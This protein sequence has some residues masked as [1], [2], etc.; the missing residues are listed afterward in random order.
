LGAAAAEW[1]MLAVQQEVTGNKI[2]EPELIIR[3]SV[4]R[5]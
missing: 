4:K 1:I 3:D 5:I 2:F